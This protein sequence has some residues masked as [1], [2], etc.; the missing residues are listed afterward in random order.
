MSRWKLLAFL[1]LI[2]IITYV[3]RVNIAVAGAQMGSALGLSRVE[4]G[5]LF[6]A[7]A[8]GYALFQIPGGWLGDR[9]GHKRVLTVALIWWSIFTSLTAWVGSSRISSAVGV[10]ASLCFVRFLIGV[11]EAAA[12]P[13]ANGLVRISF[14]PSQRG[15]ATGVILGG[16]GVGLTITPPIVAVLMLR[17][18]WESSFYI[19]GVLGVLLACVFY[20]AVQVPRE[21]QPSWSASDRSS[22]SLAARISWKDLLK[23]RQLWLLTVSSFFSGY[24][25]YIFFS[26]FYLYLV[27]VRGFTLLRGSFYAALP[28]IAATIGFP[29][30]GVLGDFL[31]ARMGAIRGRRNVVMAGMLPASLLL[32]FG[33][34]IGNS[35]LAIAALSLTAGLGALTQSSYWVIAIESVPSRTA[36]AVGITNTGFNLGG[37]CSP[38]LTPWIAARYGWSTALI[39]AAIASIVVVIVWKFLGDSTQLPLL[40]KPVVPLDGPGKQDVFD[41][42]A[43]ADVVNDQIAIS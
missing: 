33:A 17:F 42:C 8:F 9:Y 38:I 7:F 10:V 28:F 1:F 31:S 19:A 30:G 40:K 24:I 32:L 26:W 39:V 5:A 18:G 34:T 35:V 6:S 23:N 16:I 25:A 21:Q 37:V 20:F 11:G 29:L 27:E 43:R 14:P 36:T 15:R 12:Y 4:L 3:D 2:S 13:C 22:V 41:A